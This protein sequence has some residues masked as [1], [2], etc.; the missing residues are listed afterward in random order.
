MGPNAIITSP[1]FFG[2]VLAFD[3]PVRKGPNPN[4]EIV[5]W[6]Q[7]LVVFASLEEISLHMTYDIV[8]TSGEFNGSTLNLV[9]RNP[10]TRDYREFSVVGGPGA[11]QL[12]RGF[13]VDRT[14]FNSTY[15]AIF[16]YNVTQIDHA[17]GSTVGPIDNNKE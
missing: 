16:E 10:L 1:T 17:S 4:S 2:L 9:G 12:A 15:D 6:A 11:F 14:V 5:G 7:R 13:V 3:D 8:F